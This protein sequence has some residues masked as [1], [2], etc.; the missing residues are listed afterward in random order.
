MR[1]FVT[2]LT[3]FIVSILV[4]FLTFSFLIKPDIDKCKAANGTMLD[5]KCVAVQEIPL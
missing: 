3:V 4:A 5:G 2:G 1:F